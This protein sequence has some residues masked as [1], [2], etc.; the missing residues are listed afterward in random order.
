[1]RPSLVFNKQGSYLSLIWIRVVLPF[2]TC[3]H[4]HTA[5]VVVVHPIFFIIE[6]SVLPPQMGFLLYVNCV[7]SP[8]RAEGR[9]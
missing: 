5:I 3:Y 8:P 2:N 9:K 1:M 6:R 7:A 4:C